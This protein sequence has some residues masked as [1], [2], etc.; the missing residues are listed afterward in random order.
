MT[1]ANRIFNYRLSRKRRVT[2]NAFGILVGR[3][4]VFSI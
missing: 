4:R 2:K 1:D 3:F